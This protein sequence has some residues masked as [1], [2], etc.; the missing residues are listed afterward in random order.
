MSERQ[1]CKAFGCRRMTMRYKT[2]RAEDANLRQR[3][4]ASAHERR[5]FVYRRPRLAPETSRSC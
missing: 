1:A 3:M 5:R 4:K 2:T